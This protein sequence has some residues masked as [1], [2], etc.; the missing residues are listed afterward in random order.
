MAHVSFFPDDKLLVG[1]DYVF[2]SL[3]GRGSWVSCPKVNKFVEFCKL[4]EC[5][6]SV[7]DD[8]SLPSQGRMGTTP[9]QGEGGALCDEV[10]QAGFLKEADMSISLK[11]GTRAAQAGG[12]VLM[13]P[14][15]KEPGHQ[16]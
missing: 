14:P 1:W 12:L 7:K 13:S 5:Q 4:M 2:R 3:Q 11:G 10:V 6:L 16:V 8:T 9:S 15:G